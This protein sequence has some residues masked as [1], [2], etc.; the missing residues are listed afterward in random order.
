M[1][2]ETSHLSR[3]G[4]YPQ[5]EQLDSS[6]R[7][8]PFEEPED[9]GRDS[10]FGQ[11]ILEEENKECLLSVEECEVN[12]LGEQNA[13][14]LY[15]HIPSLRGKEGYLAS[16]RSLQ[17][18]MYHLFAAENGQRNLHL[19]YVG[20]VLLEQ[21]TT[22]VCKLYLDKIRKANKRKS[23]L[24]GSLGSLKKIADKVESLRSSLLEYEGKYKETA[25]RAALLMEELSSRK[26]QW[27]VLGARLGQESSVLGVMRIVQDQER[28]LSGYEDDAS[29]LDVLID[30]SGKR[31]SSVDKLIV[32][33]ERRLEEAIEEEKALTEQAKSKE[34]EAVS[35]LKK[36]DRNIVDQVKSLN[37]PPYMVGIAMEL[38]IRLLKPSTTEAR[39][40][41]E[42]DGSTSL[43][44]TG[45]GASLTSARSGAKSRKSVP[46]L[47]SLKNTSALS[48]KS[49]RRLAKDQWSR[50]QLAIGDSQ[51][52]QDLLH[53]LSWE[54]GLSQDAVTLLDANLATSRNNDPA[55]SE[56]VEAKRKMAPVHLVTGKELIAVP[57]VKHASEAAGL[58]CMFVLSVMEYHYM[59]EPCKRARERVAKLQKEVDSL[60]SRELPSLHDLL[61]KSKMP[62]LEEDVSA[63]NASDL[64]TLQKEVD[65]L[66]LEFDTV[67]VE[68]HKLNELRLQFAERLKTANQLLNN[69]K[70]KRGKWK[71]ELEAFAPERRILGECIMAGAFVV[72]GAGLKPTQRGTVLQWV[73]EV[74]K[75]HNFSTDPDF[76]IVNKLFGK[77]SC[78]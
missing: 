43:L 25:A 39:S 65:T 5:R 28:L 53:N 52:F 1:L 13:S 36:I 48:D 58:I 40:I 42:S 35:L 11:D 32:E 21:F 76:N 27:E 33:A 74:L 56:S 66:F 68:K 44:L 23:Q 41:I 19:P 24:S 38:V 49:S 70:D 8:P 30:S 78:M 20:P 45:D 72:Y 59:L 63:C 47:V 6:T 55:E 14:M 60:K 61:E 46:S 77:A 2:Q 73:Q 57:V 17:E 64:D 67:A 51:R 18:K 54:N 3:A 34:E 4:F 26:C 12:E 22:C 10:T 75:K 71:T 7:A 16:G 15:D 50:I 37:S 31:S 9:K 29:L 69:L 62:L